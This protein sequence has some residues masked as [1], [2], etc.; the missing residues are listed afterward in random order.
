MTFLQSD[1]VVHLHDYEGSCDRTL[2]NQ[3]CLSVL[4]GAIL[5]LP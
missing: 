1:L 5:I 2:I 4:T 3:N